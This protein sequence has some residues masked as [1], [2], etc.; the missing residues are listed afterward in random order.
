MAYEHIDLAA[1]RLRQPADLPSLLG[2]LHEFAVPEHWPGLIREVWEAN[3]DKP[4][5][6][7]KHLPVSRLNQSINALIPDVFYTGYEMDPESPNTWLYARKP[8]ET[9]LLK[10]LMQAYLQEWLG[11]AADFPKLRRVISELDVE[12]HAADWK[13]AAIDPAWVGINDSGTARVNPVLF[14]LIPEAIAER[15]LAKG[16]FDGELHFVQAAAYDGVELVSWPPLEHPD[17]TKRGEPRIGYYSAV[18]KIALRITPF[19]STPRLH[20]GIHTR[21][22]VSEG[23]LFIPP[24]KSAS[25]FVQ[26][27]P[28]PDTG[29][30]GTRLAT[31]SLKSYNGGKR[32]VWYRSGPQGVLDRLT[33][34]EKFPE[35]G[36]LGTDPAAYL[37]PGSPIRAA[38]THHSQMG[39]HI[40]AT[41]VMPEERRRILSWAA[42]AVEDAFEPG[43]GLAPTLLGRPRQPREYQKL[44]SMPTAPDVI[45]EPE[46]GAS[47]DEIDEYEQFLTSMVEYEA[48]KVVAETKRSIQS[49]ENAQRYRNLLSRSLDGEELRIDVVTDT[50]AVRDALVAAAQDALGLEPTSEGT[51]EGQTLFQRDGLTVRLVHHDTG[52]LTSPLGD[53]V[54]PPDVGKAHKAAVDERK[55]QVQEFFGNLGRAAKLAFVEIGSPDKNFKYRYRRADP[56]I[57]IRQGA[58]RAGRVTQ[59][60][61]TDGKGD[62]AMRAKSAWEDGIRSI[63]IAPTPRHSKNVT[64]PD[65]LVQVAIWLIRR[66]T[67]Q[68]ASAPIYMPIA[69]KIQPGQAGV[70]AKTPETDGWIPYHELLC[71]LAGAEPRPKEM[72]DKGKQ[73]EELMRFARTVVSQFKGLPTLLLTSA[74]NMR[75]RWTWL[76]DDGLELDRISFGEPKSHKLTTMFK[77]LRTVRVRTDAGR[78]ETPMWWAAPEDKDAI[79][80][81]S[82]GLWQLT[83]ADE[84][85]R[86]FYSLADKNPHIKNP[87][88]LRKFTRDGTNAPAPHRATP[89][90]KMLE[91]T[92]AGLGPGDPDPVHWAMFVHQQRFTPEF[93]EGRALP[94]ILTLCER[95]GDYASPDGLPDDGRGEAADELA[96]PEPG[97]QG[98]LF[99]DEW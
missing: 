86:V 38:V 61:T 94:Y 84:E 93:M 18:L 66:N 60:I 72:A 26:P 43:L 37:S 13:P 97:I 20:L 40:V 39:P 87:G 75:S 8:V 82:K 32:T 77:G 6:A 59:F 99:D 92:V 81:M 42:E 54:E 56:Y 89:I 34:G 23:K 27:L 48:E 70:Q 68:V 21:R 35:A 45:D 19:D 80:G 31:P 1:Y 63:G 52:T 4:V 14:R 30:Q 96:P 91:L 98:T 67:T 29:F 17:T 65:D 10:R 16:P 7:K 57:A 47:L 15:I 5:D 58:A 46:S 25:V 3:S 74:T 53:G 41:G 28:D 11:D 95:A 83:D 2:E 76:L 73:R 44:R 51:P 36:R 24:R 33:I 78:L 49:E 55:K 69:V 22:W 79:A 88:R 50:D 85:N 90:P 9:R 71:Q 64:T 62:L 12:N